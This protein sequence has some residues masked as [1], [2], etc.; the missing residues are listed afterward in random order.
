VGIDPGR[1]TW[2]KLRLMARARWEQT[3]L[4]AVLLHNNGLNKPLKDP[5]LFNA[6]AER[7]DGPAQRPATKIRMTLADL[8]P[9][10]ERAYGP[11]K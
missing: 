6:Y 4:L 3:A 2:R 10:L 5:S 8:Q 11:K 1:F 7:G 9:M